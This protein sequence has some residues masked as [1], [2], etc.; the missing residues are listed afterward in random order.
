MLSKIEYYCLKCDDSLDIEAS[1]ILEDC[2]ICGDRFCRKCTDE[3]S[4]C[5]SCSEEVSSVSQP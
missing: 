2:F 3:G 5:K 1:K 4:L